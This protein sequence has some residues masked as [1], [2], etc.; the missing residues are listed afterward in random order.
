MSGHGGNFDV[1]CRGVDRWASGVCGF[2]P[3]ARSKPPDEVAARGGGGKVGGRASARR[4]P[5]PSER[6]CDPLCTG[7]A[8]GDGASPAPLGGCQA[9]LGKS[10]S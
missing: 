8:G 4:Q 2:G 10:V 6:V 5:F 1:D 7:P 3:Q 9:R